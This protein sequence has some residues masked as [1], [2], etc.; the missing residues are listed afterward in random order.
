MMTFLTSQEITNQLR[1]DDDIADTSQ[2]SLSGDDD[3]SDTSR[4]H[5]PTKK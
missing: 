5:K 1:S 3:I 4:D 2:K